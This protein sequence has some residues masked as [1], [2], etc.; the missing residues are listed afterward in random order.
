MDIA[1]IRKVQDW[2]ECD[3]TLLKNKD[4]IKE[5]VEKKKQLEEDIIKYIEENKYENVKLNI[6][7]G[8][9]KFSKR[10]VMQ[11]LSMK[12]LKSALEKYCIEV[13][14]VDV[15]SLMKFVSSSL[16]TKQKVQMCRDIKATET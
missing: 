13:E 9:I 6:T 7:D 15:A 11:P 2:V 5:V 16:E 1:Y 8:T 14:H 3:N 4:T 10:N 12:V